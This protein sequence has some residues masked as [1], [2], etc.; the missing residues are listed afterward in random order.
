MYCKIQT[1]YQVMY[2]IFF[3]YLI[4][5]GSKHNF[6]HVVCGDKWPNPIMYNNY[7]IVSCTTALFVEYFFEVYQTLKN[8]SASNIRKEKIVLVAQ[9]GA[10][11]LL[12]KD[13]LLG[14]GNNITDD[15]SPNSPHFC[16]INITDIF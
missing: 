13:S 16:S 10:C 15:D 4:F 7:I 1:T 6:F 5:G 11:E 8:G 2:C 14:V 9:V 3:N 12:W